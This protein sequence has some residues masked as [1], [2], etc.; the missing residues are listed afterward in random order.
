[1]LIIDDVLIS[2]E[3]FTEHFQCHLE[4]CLG[5]CCQAGDYGAP[6]SE[7]EKEVLDKIN[8]TVLPYLGKTSNEFLSQS[9]GYVYEKKHKTWA[10]YCHSDG[11]CVYLQEHKDSE[12]RTCGIEK[13]FQDGEINFRKPISCHLY[14]IRI[15]KNQHLGFEAWNYDRWEI[16]HAACLLGNENRL[17]VFRFLK[18]AII[19]LKGEDFYNQ[20]EEAFIYYQRKRDM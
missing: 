17:P 8:N 13:A 1:M 18:E 5:A 2:E 12:I 19:R 14:P 10:T 11:A 6:L 7:E 9:K 3:L 4:K 15:T 16:C 20:M